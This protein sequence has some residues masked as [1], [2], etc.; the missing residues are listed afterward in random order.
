[1]ERGSRVIPCPSN[2]EDCKY[3]PNCGLSVHHTYP[4]RLVKELQDSGAPEDEVR[5]A[6]KFIN[7]PFNKVVCCRFLHDFLDTVAH[8]QLPSTERMERDVNGV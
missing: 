6:R 7:L 3:S 1:M 5:L 2:V 4:R 8:E